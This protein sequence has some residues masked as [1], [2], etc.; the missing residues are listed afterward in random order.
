MNRPDTIESILQEDGKSGSLDRRSFIRTAA[1]LSSGLVLGA[2][3]SSCGGRGYQ[4]G[5]NLI[6]FPR[7]LLHNFKLFDGKKISGS[8]LAL[9][10]LWLSSKYSQ[11][12]Y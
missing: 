1:A 4:S 12:A 7:V 2:T 6:S 11:L 5:W 9:P 3:S 8:G 10:H